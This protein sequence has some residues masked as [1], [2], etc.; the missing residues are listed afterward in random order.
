MGANKGNSLERLVAFS[1]I[2]GSGKTTLAKLLLESLRKNGMIVDYVWCR[3]ESRNLSM[4]VRVM[5]RLTKD[6]ADEGSNEMQYSD[7]KSR[8]LS[9]Q[10]VKTVYKTFVF[11]DYLIEVNLRVK[12][13]MKSVDFL[14]VDRY[15]LDVAADVISECRMGEAEANSY[16]QLLSRSMPPANVTLIV[17][18][19]L[20]VAF[21]RK[22]DIVSE[23]YLSDRLE[24]YKRLRLSSAVH[25]I[26]GT[27]DIMKSLQ[28]IQSIVNPLIN[29]NGKD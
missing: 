16:L 18:V 14:I 4:L 25:E 21:E 27:F 7:L 23:K 10:I 11:L 12:K 9:R 17:L 6:N 1:G 3:H 26:D 5:K 19:P 24:A 20:K 15:I 8:F 28:D 29:G 13:R 2:D 22:N